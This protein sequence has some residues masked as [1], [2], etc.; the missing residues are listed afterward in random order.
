MIRAD[1]HLVSEPVVDLGE[2]VGAPPPNSTKAKR[3]PTK[4]PE[5]QAFPPPAPIPAWARA[6]GRAGEGEALFFAGAGLKLFAWDAA[7]RTD[8]PAAGAP[9]SLAAA[10]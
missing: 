7:L 10:L 8:P 4:A 1:L 3:T 2:G 9:A 6:G 5:R